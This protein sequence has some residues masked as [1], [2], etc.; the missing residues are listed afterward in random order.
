MLTS[1]TYRYFNLS[2]LLLQCSHNTDNF[3]SRRSRLHNSICYCQ[4][5]RRLPPSSLNTNSSFDVHRAVHRNIISIVKPT[6]CT[7]VWNL[8]IS[9]W[10]STCFGDLSVHHL[11][12]VT[13]HTT[14]SIC[15]TDTAVCLLADTRRKDRSKHVESSSSSSSSS[16]SWRIRRVSCSLILTIKLVPPS[17]PR[18]SYVPSSFWFIL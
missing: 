12:F 14:K 6:G 7:S 9:E 15:Q 2:V 5:F 4:G 16:C 3:V 10:H 11:E 1:V 17:L 13:V 18:S 8:F